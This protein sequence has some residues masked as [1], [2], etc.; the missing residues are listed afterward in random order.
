MAKHKPKKGF[1]TWFEKQFGSR[2][3]YK[4]LAKLPDE[5]LCREINRS[6]QLQRELDFRI[7]WDKRRDAALKAWCANDYDSRKK[8]K[9]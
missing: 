5:A 3:V 7:E 4:D 1:G 6:L 8:R 2:E 9:K